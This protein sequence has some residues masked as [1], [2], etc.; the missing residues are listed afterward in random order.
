MKRNLASLGTLNVGEAEEEEE[1]ERIAL[2]LLVGFKG[3]EDNKMS[4]EIWN[5]K[6]HQRHYSISVRGLRRFLFFLLGNRLE[7]IIF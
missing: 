6:G 7:L 1:E 2:S 5:T 4:T 3:C